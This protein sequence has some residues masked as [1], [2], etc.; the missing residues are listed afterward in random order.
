MAD[1]K[2]SSDSDEK[3]AQRRAKVAQHTRKADEAATK[4]AEQATKA[5]P[6][7]YV[8]MTGKSLTTCRGIVGPG[9]PVTALDFCKLPDL[10]EHG[11]ARLDELIGK[12]YVHKAGSHG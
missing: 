3:K 1:E 12:G 7:E 5:K 6:A 4:V 9:L 2:S 10:K 8:V 11:L